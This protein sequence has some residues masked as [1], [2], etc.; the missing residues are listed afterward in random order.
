MKKVS[1]FTLVLFLLSAIAHAEPYRLGHGLKLHDSIHIGGYF[2]TDYEVGEEKRLLRLD[3]V[4][5]LGYGNI[6]PKFSYLVEL[7]AAPYYKRDFRNHYQEYDRKFHYE[8]LYFDYHFSEY[9]NF[10]IGKLITPIGYWNLEPINVLRETSSSPS[11]SK[12]MFPKFL[13]GLDIYGY[14]PGVDTLTYHL[15]MQNSKDIDEDYI[16]IKNRHFFGL[17]LENQMSMDFQYGGSV[18]EYITEDTTRTRFFQL[19]AKYEDGAINV[20]AEAMVNHSENSSFVHETTKFSGYLQSEYHFNFQHALI[21]RYEYFD[22]DSVTLSN[23]IGI[24]GYSYRPI[25]PV[26][27]KAEYQINSDS[28]KNKFLASFSVLF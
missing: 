27:L 9:A 11:L 18:G 20:Q 7:E 5:L 21:G 8:R 19:N 26:S 3:D 6:T 22:D 4:A 15:F 1:L 12:K 14:V 16:N 10:R 17:S 13:T 28:S 23:H 2:S 24:F 25:Y